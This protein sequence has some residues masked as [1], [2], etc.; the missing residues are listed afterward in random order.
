MNLKFSNIVMKSFYLYLIMLFIFSSANSKDPHD[1][2]L[3]GKNL[4]CFNESF[5]VE[6]W[7]IKFLENKK[8]KLFSLEK[9]M[10]EIYQYPRSYRT[11]LR[12]IIIMKLG[13]IEYVINRKR[14]IFGNKQCK[15]VK[16][17]PLVL[18]QERVKDLKYKRKK[19]NKI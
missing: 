5:S 7:G 11:N 8:V 10:Y 17:D 4:I 3:V 15:I 16:G 12:N 6:D 14:L 2:N 18:L 9:T 19:G 1:D 13:K